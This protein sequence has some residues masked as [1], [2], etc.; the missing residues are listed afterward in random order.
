MHTIN[1]NIL[2][3]SLFR[4]VVVSSAN[5][6]MV[7]F[8]LL[9]CQFWKYSVMLVQHKPMSETHHLM[10]IPHWGHVETFHLVLNLCTVWVICILEWHICVRMSRLKHWMHIYAFIAFFMCFSTILCW[11]TNLNLSLHR[12]SQ[13]CICVILMLAQ[14]L[15]SCSLLETLA[16]FDIVNVKI[17]QEISVG[18]L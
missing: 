5:L 9:P 3:L 1:I 6:S 7:I 16:A 10:M 13:Q 2:I 11:L 18:T 15:Q 12:S 14:Q 8:F 17:Y 4:T